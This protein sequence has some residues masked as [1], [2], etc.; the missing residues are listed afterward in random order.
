M[1]VACSCSRRSRHQAVPPLYGGGPRRWRRGV[2]MQ[3]DPDDIAAAEA[4]VV[5]GAEAVA[6]DPP[7]DE[8]IPDDMTESSGGSPRDM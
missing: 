4:E 7:E 8:D 2:L 3:P 1:G 5:A 6:E